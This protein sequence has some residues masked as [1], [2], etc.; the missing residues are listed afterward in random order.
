[1]DLKDNIVGYW[2]LRAQGYS[3]ANREEFADKQSVYGRLLTA[4]ASKITSPNP[5]ALDLGCGPGFFSLIL[6][7]MGFH[8]TGVDASP[9]MIEQARANAAENGLSAHFILSD[10]IHPKL[11]E[12]YD[13][14]VTRNLVWNLTDPATAYKNWSKLLKQNGL[15]LI[16][17][18]NH[19][20]YLTEPKYRFPEGPQ[21]SH[22]HIGQVDPSVME[23]I[24][25]ELPMT[26]HL[27]PQYDETLLQ[28]NGLVVVAEQILRT[29]SRGDESLVADFLIVAGREKKHYAD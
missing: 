15:M 24:A 18:G 26:K 12:H 29:V 3:L 20:Y 4:W 13:L 11:S 19:Y 27:R 17:D 21:S 6:S 7:Q 25:T 1:M 14:I 2:D 5:K 22:K 28:A 16:F 10:A 23:K 9:K 8:V